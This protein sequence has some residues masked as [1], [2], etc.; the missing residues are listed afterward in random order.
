LEAALNGEEATR[1]LFAES[2]YGSD[3]QLAEKRAARNPFKRQH[4]FGD[5]PGLRRFFDFINQPENGRKEF[6]ERLPWEE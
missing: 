2:R 4:E 3:G 6:P 1:R 5:C